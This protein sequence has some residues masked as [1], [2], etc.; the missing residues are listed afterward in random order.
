MVDLHHP[1]PSGSATA[2][3]AVRV[4]IPFIGQRS[5][6]HHDAGVWPMRL[7]ETNQYHL[8][9]HGLSWL[10]PLPLWAACSCGYNRPIPPSLMYHHSHLHHLLLQGPPPG[11]FPIG[12]C[13]QPHAFLTALH[14]GED[15]LLLTIGRIF[16]LEQRRVTEEF[17]LIAPLPSGSLYSL[18]WATTRVVLAPTLTVPWS[19]PRVVLPCLKVAV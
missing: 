7:R 15:P 9:C 6:W 5:I 17:D 13:L 11:E 18:A 16:R 1:L 8:N 4:Y 14:I 3:S 19:V 10:H 12:R 2:L